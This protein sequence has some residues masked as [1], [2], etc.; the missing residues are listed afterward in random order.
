MKTARTDYSRSVDWSGTKGT[1]KE[2]LGS[3]ERQIVRFVGGIR[4]PRE[5]P[6]TK[7]QILRWFRCT[8]EE[9]VGQAI[10]E[11]VAN[12]RI[13]VSRNGIRHGRSAVGY[14]YELSGASRSTRIVRV[15]GGRHWTNLAI[16]RVERG[17]VADCRVVA[18]QGGKSCP[19]IWNSGCGYAS[20]RASILSVAGSAPYVRE[21]VQIG[22]RF[23]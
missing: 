22:K 1:P 6:V 23:Q 15:P 11:A 3:L 2:R 5:N 10:M 20:H 17:A 9:F 16:V 13:R 21:G 7:V 12:D 19:W 8:P 14:V 18:E 4:G